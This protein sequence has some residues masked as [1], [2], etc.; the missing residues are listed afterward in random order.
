MTT[1]HYDSD[2]LLHWAALLKPTCFSQTKLL[3]QSV[4]YL[5]SSNYDTNSKNEV[6]F[7]LLLPHICQKADG[8]AE[9]CL[10][11]HS[12]AKILKSLKRGLTECFFA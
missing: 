9:V 6:A 2:F 3:R 12:P 5:S 1:S 8:K 11:F 10:L 7:C 4:D